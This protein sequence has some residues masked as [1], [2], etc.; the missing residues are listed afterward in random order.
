MVLKIFYHVG[1]SSQTMKALIPILVLLLLIIAALLLIPKG[2][3]KNQP[4]SLTGD[5]LPG[6]LLVKFKPSATSEIR[7]ALKS[8][9]K[10]KEENYIESISVYHWKGDFDVQKAVQEL[11]TSGQILYAEPNY[12][13]HT[14][15]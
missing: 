15:K 5:Y 3:G 14:Q 9:L 6:E 4:K 2:S 11:Q 12:K 10:V 8:K 13:V 1:I 7:E